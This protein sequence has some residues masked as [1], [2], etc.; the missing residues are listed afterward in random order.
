MSLLDG[1]SL[2]PRCGNQLTSAPGRVECRGCGFELYAHSAV[3]ASALPEDEQGRVLLARRGIEPWKGK[4]DCIGGFLD[5]GEHPV[6]GLRREVREETGL[7]FDV[8]RLLGIW[9]GRY[10]GRATLNLF[11]TGVLGPGVPAPDD[12][13]S[14]LR[15]FARDELPASGELAFHPLIAD[16]LDAWREE[17]L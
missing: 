2:C 5:E 17:Q 6:D 15:S 7:G 8:G 14:E 1:W 16:V 13:I 3:T 9:M 4:W 11:W 10:G 12:D